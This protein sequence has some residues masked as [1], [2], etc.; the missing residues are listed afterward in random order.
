MIERRAVLKGLVLG[1]C[2]APRSAMAQPPAKVWRIGLLSLWYSTSDP[3][4]RL[5]ILDGLRRMGYRQGQNLVVENRYADGKAEQLPAL[6]SDLV[7][8]RVD[9][10]VALSTQAG[11]AAK[12]A[13]S[14]VPI[15]VAACG[16]LVGSGL[17]ADP[18]RPGGNLT[19]LQFLSR[20]LAV[21]QMELLKQISPRTARLALLGDPDDLSEVAFYK[22]MERSAP[23]AGVTVRFVELRTDNDLPAAFTAM[24]GSRVDGLAVASSVSQRDP[25][26]KIVRQ[27]AKNR[28]PAIYPGAQF[29]KEG[30]LISY[31]TDL[32]EQGH[33]AAAYVSRILKGAKAGDLPVEQP[34]KFDLA[35]NAKTAKALGLTVPPALVGR[36]DE[37]TR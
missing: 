15:V 5:G 23:S 6:A 12:Q 31:F 29:V 3:A 35:V 20:E 26:M 28:I 13:T 4:L 10:I 14:T 21:R 8:R 37:V 34:T 30:G 22:I 16:D 25:S 33:H 24:V 32:S 9:L 19:G 17:V 18:S 27:A 2:L 36:A 11:L 1:V 7:Q